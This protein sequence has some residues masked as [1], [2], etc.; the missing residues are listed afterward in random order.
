MVRGEYRRAAELAQSALDLWT[1]WDAFPRT[2]V[3][4]KHR[5]AVATLLDGNPRTAAEH[6]EPVLLLFDRVAPADHDFQF[7]VVLIVCCGLL[8][9]RGEVDSAEALWRFIEDD[10]T[11]PDFDIYAIGVLQAEIEEAVRGRSDRDGAPP[12]QDRA[13][14][15]D[16]ALDRVAEMTRPV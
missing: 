7:W 3:I 4:L 2:L 14:A 15:T 1:Y 10:V 16:L 13:Q 12:V 9:R 6:L 11:V 8:V 5:M